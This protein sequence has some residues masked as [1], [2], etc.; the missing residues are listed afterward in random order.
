M[1]RIEPAMIRLHEEPDLRGPKGI[2]FI[3]AG[4]RMR[5]IH[6]GVSRII[7]CWPGP[8]SNRAV[9]CFPLRGWMECW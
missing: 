1:A 8:L 2:T 4:T 6:F 5:L 9:S 3:F 7:C